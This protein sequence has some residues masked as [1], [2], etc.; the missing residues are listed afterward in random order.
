MVGDPAGPRV[1]RQPRGG[2]AGEAGPGAAHRAAG[3]RG[4]RAVGLLL[5]PV[6]EGHRHGGDPRTR[7]RRRRERAGLFSRRLG[8]CWGG[9][10]GGVTGGHAPPFR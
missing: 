8:E 1:V 6:L 10:G 3:D 2:R 4:R 7:L 5:L 9:G